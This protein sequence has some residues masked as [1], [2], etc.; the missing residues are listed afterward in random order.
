MLKPRRLR[1][2]DKVAAISLSWG[3]PSAFP[4]RYEAGKR[5]FVEA[6]GVEV[7]E[8]AHALKDPAWLAKHP[9]ARAS[10]LMEAFADRSISGIISTI[11]IGRAHV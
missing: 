7:V 3:G 11:E 10:D 2:G 8:T 9:E 1:P 6:F 4:R 5:Q